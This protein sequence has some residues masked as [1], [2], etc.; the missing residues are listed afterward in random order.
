M[1]FFFLNNS[2]LE[3]ESFQEMGRKVDSGEKKKRKESVIH[4]P[5]LRTTFLGEDAG[6]YPCSL[7]LQLG[8]TSWTDDQ[9]ITGLKRLYCLLILYKFRKCQ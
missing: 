9:S 3:R 8:K 5:I 6:A 4:L 1:N 2:L 7:R